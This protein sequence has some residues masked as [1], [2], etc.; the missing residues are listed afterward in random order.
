MKCKKEKC[1]VFKNLFISPVV[2]V[3]YLCTFV[4]GYIL[5]YCLYQKIITIQ[6]QAISKSLHVVPQHLKPFTGSQP[7]LHPLE[8]G[9]YSPPF[10]CAWIEGGSA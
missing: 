1:I 8:S 6:S 10:V 7:G 3:V 2:V 4:L 5:R 9:P